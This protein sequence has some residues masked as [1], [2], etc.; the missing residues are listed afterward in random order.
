VG[1][2]LKR[3]EKNIFKDKNLWKAGQ[4][5]VIGGGEVEPESK[6]RKGRKI[7][8]SRKKSRQPEVGMGVPKGRGGNLPL[9]KKL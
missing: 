9:G 6:P 8:R 2:I 7:H 4:D 1:G 3:Q 5:G